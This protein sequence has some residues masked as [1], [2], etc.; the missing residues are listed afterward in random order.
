MK[1]IAT[2]NSSLVAL[3]T[4]ALFSC[5][6][7]TGCSSR[8]KPVAVALSVESTKPGTEYKL[9][10]TVDLDG[11][12]VQVDQKTPYRFAGNGIETNAKLVSTDADCNLSAKYESGA[13]RD[14]TS[15]AIGPVGCEVILSTKVM[16]RASST[17]IQV[18]ALPVP[19][20]VPGAVPAPLPAAV[21]PV[22]APAVVPAPAAEVIPAPAPSPAAPVAPV[23]PTVVP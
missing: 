19:S 2:S 17:Q 11:K 22:P 12:K 8:P 18:K 6:L 16:E 7:T 14:L 13:D 3:V 1:S 15:Q 21:A 4:C 5:A 10:G 20:P 23:A 9:S